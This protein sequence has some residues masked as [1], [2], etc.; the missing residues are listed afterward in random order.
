[1]KTFFMTILA[2]ALF[3]T[4]WN[5]SANE[6]P[7][8]DVYAQSYAVYLLY[9]PDNKDQSSTAIKKHFVEDYADL[10]KNKNKVTEVEFVA[11][12]QSRLQP[13]M[14]QR[15]EMSLKQ[16]HVRFGILDAN[17]NGQMTLK[18]FQDSGVKT[19]EGMDKNNDGLINAE[20]VKA[21]GTQTGTHDGFRVRLP[22]SMPMANTAKEFI[23][24]YSQ[25]KTYAT[26]GDYLVARDQQFKDT[27][28]NQDLLL[29]EQEYVDEFMQRFDANAVQG[30]EKMK[31]LS[32]QK[33]QAISGSKS[34]IQAKDIEKFAKQL[35]RAISQ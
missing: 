29:T 10:F 26:L 2:T 1:M 33:F 34:T 14:K 24:K 31:A 13:L 25:G 15:R 21:S 19:F 4:S 20:D 5:A 16:A 6:H 22:I 30:I 18:E 28:R 11:Y 17:K 27:D 32:A 9:H 8:T 7:Q 35:D 12:E 23:E 3:A